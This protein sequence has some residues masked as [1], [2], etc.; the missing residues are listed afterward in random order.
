MSAD[1]IDWDAARAA[2]LA[3][4]A[5][6]VRVAPADRIDGFDLLAQVRRRAGADPLFSFAV[7]RAADAARA[8]ARLDG[9]GDPA[10]LAAGVA[11]TLGLGDMPG[12]AEDVE[13]ERAVAYALDHVI[14]Q[15]S[16]RYRDPY[17]LTHQLMQVLDALGFEVTP[18]ETPADA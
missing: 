18:K 9:R 7:R 13:R 4:I 8:L 14:A 1:G 6:G 16:A 5:P 10:R 11:L 3:G 15:A 12:R 17:A 2:G